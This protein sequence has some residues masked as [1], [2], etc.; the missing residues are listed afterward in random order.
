LLANQLATTPSAPCGAH[1]SR[2]RLPGH[3]EQVFRGTA[4]ELDGQGGRGE[5][6]MPV[7]MPIRG[8]AQYSPSRGRVDVLA[9]MHP[10]THPD[11]RDGAFAGARRAGARFLAVEIDRDKENLDAQM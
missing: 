3:R 5:S 8:P 9:C 11:H 10:G 6:V 4:H 2:S 1:G 7:P